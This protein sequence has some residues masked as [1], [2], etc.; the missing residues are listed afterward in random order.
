MADWPG[1]LLPSR[2]PG[3]R[4][5]ALGRWATV[6]GV[7][8]LAGWF[9]FPL[10]IGVAVLKYRLFDIDRIISRTLAYAIVTGLLVGDVCGDRA[11]RH[12]GAAVL[13]V[14]SRSRWRPW[15]RRRCSIRCGARVQ[16][17]SGPAVQPGSLRRRPDDRRVRS[18]A[19]KT[20]STWTPCG[21]TWPV[22]YNR[23]WSPSTSR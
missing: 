17:T 11:A 1:R 12:P 8:A 16:K 23:P 13:R 10:C 19:A 7:F 18:P 4:A 20:Q 2:A 6:G 22:P 3:S 15:P 9:A 14:R 5:G 21:P